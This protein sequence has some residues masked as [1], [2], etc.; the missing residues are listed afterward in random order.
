MLLLNN[1]R[2]IFLKI[3]EESGYKTLQRKHTDGQ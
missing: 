3:D 1:I 2:K